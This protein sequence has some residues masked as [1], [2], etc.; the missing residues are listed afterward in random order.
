MNRFW[1]ILFFLVPLCGL[2]AFVLAAMGLDPFKGAWL[3]ENYSESGKAIDELWYLVHYVCA[4]F[5]LLTGLLIGLV[6]WKCTGV[7]AR[8]AAFTKSSLKLE[9]VWTVIPAAILVALA[10]YQLNAWSAQRVQ[11]PTIM[12]NGQKTER[13]PLVKVIARQFGWTFVY[14]GEDSI[15]NT[16][17]DISVENLMVVP[18]DESIVMELESKDVIHSFFVPKLRLK[19]DM[20][21]GMIQFAWFKP[22]R[23]GELDIVCAELCGW[24]HYKMNAR[25]KIVSRSE[26]DQ[27][28]VQQQ[29]RIRAPQLD[30]VADGGP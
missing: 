6:T 10:F 16:L 9:V 5:F 25:M 11:R 15:F 19:N 27:W 30:P 22:T 2:T 14:A 8:S 17:D 3:P 4:F 23:T 7:N 26:F 28:I 24:G 12:V 29:D 13:P 1:S 18:V 20:V 21:P